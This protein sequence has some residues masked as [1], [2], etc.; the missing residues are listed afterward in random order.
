MLWFVNSS[1]LGYGDV[2]LSGVLGTDVPLLGSVP[3]DPAL[4]RGGDAGDPVV[5]GAPDSP[6]ARALA[7]VAARLAVRSQSLRG[8]G[9]PLRPR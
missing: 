9:L 7:D 1:G 8:R 4:R 2:R 3:L 5:L 6:A